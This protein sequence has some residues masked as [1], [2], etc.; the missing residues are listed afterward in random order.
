MLGSKRGRRAVRRLPANEIRAALVDGRVWAGLGVVYQ[1]DS[2]SHYDVDDELGVLVHVRLMPAEEPLLC[3]LGGLG[4][5]G[6]GGVWR[7]PPVGTEVVVVIPSGDIDDDPCIVAT[8]ASGGTPGELDEDTLV[9]K[10]PKV[11]I[12]ATG[13]AVEIG[14]AGL[15]TTDGLVH[16]TGIDPF[17]GATYAALNNTSSTVRAKK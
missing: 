9:V 17:T 13:G 4:S 12:I 3:R 7:I 11:T 1:D 10:A 5:G 6:D 14:E 15:I 8:L 16:G 2:G